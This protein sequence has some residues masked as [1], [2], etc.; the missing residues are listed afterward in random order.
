M[1]AILALVERILS[2]VSALLPIVQ[3][4]FAR[5]QR[6]AQESTPYAIES[7]ANEALIYTGNATYGTQAIKNALD[8][9]ISDILA[10]ISAV[11]YDAAPGHLATVQD[12]L[13]A[14]TAGVTVITLP[15]PPPAGYGGPT[16]ASVWAETYQTTGV[17]FADLL[18]RAGTESWT[19]A[20][21][22]NIPLADAPWFTFENIGRLQAGLGNPIPTNMGFPKPD[23]SAVASYPTVLAWLNA[24]DTWHGGDWLL[25]TDSSTAYVDVYYL[26]TF[27]GTVRCI[28]TPADWAVI[29]GAVAANAGNVPPIWPGLAKVTLGTPVAL[30]TNTTVPGPLD[31][32]LIDVSTPPSGLGGWLVGGHRWWFRAGQIAFVTDNGDVEPW[33]YLTWDQ[34]VYVPK[35][36]RQAASAI[37]RMLGTGGGTATPWLAT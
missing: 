26:A 15:S 27:L 23:Y 18:A 7:A 30:S 9:G 11:R 13:D 25:D 37:L 31:G 5:V 36:M 16:P 12:V 6:A 21:W 32:V 1:T 22:S 28:L 14:L 4:V 29:T 20:Y 35:S 3:A 24:T 19:R 17:T 34:A 33:Q 10:A 8:T 2:I